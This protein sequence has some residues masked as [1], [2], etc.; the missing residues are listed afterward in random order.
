MIHIFKQ[1]PALQS[2]VDVMSS[3]DLRPLAEKTTQQH[4]S[5]PWECRMCS[6]APYL[7]C[8]FI[9]TQQGVQ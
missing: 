6:Y 4:A 7:L 8:E 3:Q 9:I 5:E 1:Y 2:S